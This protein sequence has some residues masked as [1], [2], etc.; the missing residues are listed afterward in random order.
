M[1]L[2]SLLLFFLHDLKN[3]SIKNDVSQDNN[4]I[5]YNDNYEESSFDYVKNNKQALKASNCSTS[6]SQNSIFLFYFFYA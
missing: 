6:N 2:Y 4:F 1:H 5:S 3:D